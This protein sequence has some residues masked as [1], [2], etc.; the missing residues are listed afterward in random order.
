MPMSSVQRDRLA[1]DL[2][3]YFMLF[4]SV[5]M[6]GYNT[7]D[8]VKVGLNICIKYVILIV[9]I[10]T[11]GVRDYPYVILLS[12]GVLITS[13]LLCRYELRVIIWNTR[14][15]V[16]DETSITGERMSDIYVK[17]WMS[18]MYDDRQKT[19]VHYRHGLFASFSAFQGLS[20]MCGPVVEMVSGLALFYL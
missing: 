1:S 14:D 3:D 20:N 11:S 19:D 8:I 13:V 7:V 4:S 17:A 18:G 2:V 9:L 10:R 16:L 12:F 6:D 5:F 15:V